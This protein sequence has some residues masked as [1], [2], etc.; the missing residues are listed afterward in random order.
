MLNLDPKL[1]SV[2]VTAALTRFATYLGLLTIDPLVESAIALAAGA[3]A[4]YFTPND[5]TIL[6]TEQPDGNAYPPER[7]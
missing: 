1:V 5:G 4:G 7:A 6:R 3:V 2:V